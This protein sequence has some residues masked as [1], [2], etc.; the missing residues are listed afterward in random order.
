MRPQP[1]RLY[2]E[3][4]AALHV[5]RNAA[6]GNEAAAHHRA[7]DPYY[8]RLNDRRHDG[9]MGAVVGL[10]KPIELLRRIEEPPLTLE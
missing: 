7:L 8:E 5:G 1:L 2:A 4:R 6:I 3:P 9:I 10:G